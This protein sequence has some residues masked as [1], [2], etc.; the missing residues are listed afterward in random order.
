MEGTT[1]MKTRPFWLRCVV[2]TTNVDA[3]GAD[4]ITTDDDAEQGTEPD[5]SD[6]PPKDDSATPPLGDAGKKA[7]NAERKAR[8]D[9]EKALAD[10]Q[11][12]VKEFEQAQMSEQERLA[13]QLKEAQDAA[14]KATAEALRLR[15]AS[16]V[17]L[18][19]ELHEFLDGITDEEQMRARAQKLAAKAGGSAPKKTPDFGG[20]KRGDDPTSVASLEQRIAEAQKDGDHRL[21]ISLQRERSRLLQA[22]RK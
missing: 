15:I 16:E 10:A 14:A 2:D 7:L 1:E 12:K 17:G 21:S 9:A 11:A 20:G 22:G 8:R 13:T 4:V 3:G 19:P 6:T 18:D 5:T